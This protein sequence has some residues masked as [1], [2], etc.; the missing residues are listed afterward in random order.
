M[1][2][3]LERSYSG[4]FG[5]E[6]LRPQQ[7]NLVDL[8]ERFKGVRET[9][10]AVCHHFSQPLTV[11]MCLIDL[12]MIKGELKED[13]EEILVNMK[14]QAEIMQDLLAKLR[15]VESYKVKNYNGYKMLNIEE[16]IS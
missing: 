14:K 12:L 7:H 5:Q 15:K 9:V 16:N 6:E 2:N 3:A 4:S 8:A 11:I 13:S 1:A 10:L